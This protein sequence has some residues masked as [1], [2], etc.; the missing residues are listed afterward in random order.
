MIEANIF[1]ADKSATYPL[2][3]NESVLKS[4]NGDG[5]NRNL[6]KEEEQQEFF[7]IKK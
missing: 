2:L 1:D 7:E 6:Y 3:H 5:T 4:F